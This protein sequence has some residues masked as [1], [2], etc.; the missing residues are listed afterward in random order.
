MVVL[1]LLAVAVSARF[2]VP[3]PGTP[4]PQS[5]QT[6]AVLLVGL[7]LGATDGPIALLAYLF[8]GAVGLPVFADGASG[9]SHLVGPAAGYLVGFVV[10]AGGI[11]WL[12]D[13]HKLGRAGPA[14]AWMLVAHASIL[15]LGWIR[16]GG[17]LGLADAYEQGVAP[18]LW[19]GVAK[20]LVAAAIAVAWAR[21]SGGGDEPKRG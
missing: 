18:F 4:V 20:S 15:M 2:E 12:A 17:S 14:L 6:L 19:G 5:A 1:A 3:V 21:Y 10:A 16:L 11:G 8:C 7:A 9:W 13:R